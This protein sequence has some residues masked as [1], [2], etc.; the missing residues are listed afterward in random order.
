MPDKYDIDLKPEAEADLDYY[1]AGVRK[2]IAD[3]IEVQLSHE[4]TKETKNRK[5]LRDHPLARWELRCERY[6]VF[7]EV[8]EDARLVTVVSV[9]HKERQRLFVRGKE[10]EL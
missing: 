1:K 10:V 7:Y 3:A 8:D 6:R 2:T 9:G 5:A 4:P